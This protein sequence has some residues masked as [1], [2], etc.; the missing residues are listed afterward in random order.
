MARSLSNTFLVT[1][2]PLEFVTHQTELNYYVTCFF[3]HTTLME[4]NCE[5]VTK[6]ALVGNIYVG[7][8]KDIIKNLNAAFVE[9][10]DGLVCY[11]P[12][13]DNHNPIYTK[14][15]SGTKLTPGDEVLVQVIRDSVKTKG[16]TITTNL[17]LSGKYMVLTTGNKKVGVSAKIKG[18][19]RTQLQE[20]MNE[21]PDFPYG[22]ILRTNA[23]LVEKEVLEEE[24]NR[25]KEQLDT[26]IATGMH[27]TCYSCLYKRGPSFLTRIQ[28]LYSNGET[29]IIT[30]DPQIYEE[31]HRYLSEQ[32][33]EDLGL[34]QFYEDPSYPLKK[35]YG[36]ESKLQ[37]ALNEKVWL[38]SGA[39]LIIQH[40]EA[41]TVIDVNSGKNISRKNPQENFLNINLEAGK[42]I[43]RQLKL[44]NIS[45]IC[46]ID[47]IDMRA[48]ESKEEL[49][50][51]LRQDCSLDPIPTTVIDMTKL[52]LVEVTRKKVNKPLYEQLFFNEKH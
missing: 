10:Q 40:T 15:S 19:L 43:A 51:V 42:E 9:I 18:E 37:D 52:G 11:L 6:T 47:F 24:C 7:R 28:G 30:D 41:M 48:E 38:K 50:R 21:T 8:V 27:R 12:L 45:G 2:T 44:R 4:V 16:P 5:P 25:L 22:R 1:K 29:K 13:E 32:Q 36:I 46:M 33:P 14:Q 17:N 34:L 3:N 23:S 31:I 39:Y 49:M 26:L 35:L 20:F